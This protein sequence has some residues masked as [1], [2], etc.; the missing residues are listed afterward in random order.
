MP[1]SATETGLA[2]FVLKPEEMPGK[3]VQ[4]VTHAG[5]NGPGFVIGILKNHLFFVVV[6]S[7]RFISWFEHV[8]EKLGHGKYGFGGFGFVGDNKRVGI[9]PSAGFLE[10]QCFA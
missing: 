8:V 4:L 3:L 6:S 5:I 7:H 2:D 9:W 10:Y 1:R